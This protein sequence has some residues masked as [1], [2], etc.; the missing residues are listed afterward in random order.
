MTSTKHDK[1]QPKDR[2]RDDLKDNPAIGQ[3]K[4]TTI[5]GEDPELI[6][7]ENTVEGD[8]EN[9]PDAIGR[10]DGRKLGRTNA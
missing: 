6:A 5:A 7:G 4:G 10:A 3:S 9:D 8:V 1:T 2:P